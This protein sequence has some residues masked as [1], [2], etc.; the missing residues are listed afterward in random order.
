[1]RFAKENHIFHIQIQEGQLLKN[2]N[3]NQSTVHWKTVDNFTVY[4]KLVLRNR[5]YHN[6]TWFSR[7]VN[8][9]S[10][11]SPLNNVLTGLRFQSE[12]DHLKLEIQVTPFDFYTGELKSN[13]SSWISKSNSV[14]VR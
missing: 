9:D 10:I 7:S 11:D 6:V 13:N 2:G 12:D 4:D 1:M 5:D 14:Y 3:I 8:L